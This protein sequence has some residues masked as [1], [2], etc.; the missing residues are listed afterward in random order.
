MKSESDGGVSI[1][2]KPPTM[3]SA[4]VN[5]QLK[6]LTC[7]ITRSTMAFK[8]MPSKVPMEMKRGKV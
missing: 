5:F 8:G 3:K 1:N 6:K 4:A 2:I 7:L